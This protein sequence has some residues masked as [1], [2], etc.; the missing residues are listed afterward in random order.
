MTATKKRRSDRNH[1]IYLATNQITDESY[2][3][4][5][6]AKGRAYKKSARSRWLA[7]VYRA[8]VEQA[9]LPLSASIR[10][11]GTNAFIVQILEVVRGKSSAHTREFEL[12]QEHKPELNVLGKVVTA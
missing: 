3:G 12:I 1:V 11:Y 7:H 5:T 10:N 9:A 8:E 6:V 4:I 2:I